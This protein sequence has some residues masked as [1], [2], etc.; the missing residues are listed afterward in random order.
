VI[1]VGAKGLTRV[2]ASVIPIGARLILVG[3][4]GLTRVGAS[5]I[6]VGAGRS[7]TLAR[8]EGR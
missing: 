3:A 1:L 4:R 6:L 7:L 5:V 2:G 8:C